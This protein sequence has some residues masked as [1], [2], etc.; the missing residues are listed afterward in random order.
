M[1]AGNRSV[2]A[3]P[4]GKLASIGAA[5][6]PVVNSEKN[7]NTTIS[8]HPKITLKPKIGKK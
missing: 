2:T 5:K 3:S 8:Q 7:R 1:N 4:K 6:S